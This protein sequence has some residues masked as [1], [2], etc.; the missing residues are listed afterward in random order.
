MAKMFTLS[1]VPG[2]LIGA[3]VGLLL[4]LVM[5]LPAVAQDSPSWNK[6]VPKET[7]KPKPTPAPKPPVKR[8]AKATPRPAPRPRPKQ[9]AQPL[10]AVQF[11]VFKVNDN[12]SQVEVNPLTVFN[13][14][15]RIRIAMKANQDVYLYVI[16]QPAAT[17]DGSIFFPDSRINSGQNFLVRDTEVVLPGGCGAG[18]LPQDCALRVDANP[19]PEVFTMILSRSPSIDLLENQTT[20]ITNGLK[21]QVLEGYLR[22]ANLKLD[23]SGRADSIF[24][25]MVRNTDP[26]ANDKII[27]RYLL[28]KRG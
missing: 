22:N 15:D 21:P 14:G 13:K 11:R 27:V 25:R 20:A 1:N 28:N 3:V 12:N 24:G 16:R 10:L 26:K 19:G 9:P 5:A 7:P 8:A 17:D 23:T 6:T 18:V 2:R 4:M